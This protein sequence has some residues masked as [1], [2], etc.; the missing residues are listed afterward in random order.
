MYFAQRKL[1]YH[2]ESAKPILSD[3]ALSDGS[4]TVHVPSHD[5]LLLYS[6]YRKPKDTNKPLIVYFHGNAG[7]IGERA[8]KLRL[9][10]DHGYGFLICSYRYNAGNNGK[11]SEEALIRDGQAVINWAKSKGHDIDDI[12]LYGESLGSGI[13]VSLGQNN[14]VKAIVLEGPYSSVLDVAADRYKFLPVNMLI[15]DEF[16]SHKYIGNLIQPILIVHGGDDK[17]IPVK[18]AKK[19]HASTNGQAEL[20]IIEQAGHADLYDHG[21]GEIVTKFVNKTSL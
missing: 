3:Y 1:L 9:F 12:I 11:P 14:L 19:L 21:A 5:G 20:R 18:F 8:N 13:A 4:D 16:A 10:R 17:T 6:W 2:P 15:K 7:D